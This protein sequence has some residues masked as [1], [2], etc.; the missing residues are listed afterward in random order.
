MAI[1]QQFARLPATFIFDRRL[2]D[3]R[4]RTLCALLAYADAEGWCY[5]SLKTLSN[6]LGRARSTVSEHIGELG[7]LGYVTK[8]A[9]RRQDN[10]YASNGYWVARERPVEAAAMPAGRDP[11]G[12]PAHH[13]KQQSLLLPI[14]G[15]RNGRTPV[16]PSRIGV[17]GQGPDT[18]SDELSNTPVRSGT[19]HKEQTN[20]TDQRTPPRRRAPRGLM[21]ATAEREIRG[22]EK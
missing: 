11:T 2:S 8:I 3:A 12:Q 10:G 5:P 19:E 21:L 17:F 22:W 15:K 6:G 1:Q 14:D 20:R 13:A 9:R 4:L 7:R 16:R 18:L